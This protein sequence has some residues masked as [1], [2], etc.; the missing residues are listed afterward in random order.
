M[1]VCMYECMY[2]YI[3]KPVFLSQ[4]VAIGI[5]FTIPGRDTFIL[6]CFEMFPTVGRGQSEMKASLLIKV[7]HSC[8]CNRRLRLQFRPGALEPIELGPI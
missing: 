8:I 1:Y 3:S 6:G 5:V 7:V 2:V 4:D